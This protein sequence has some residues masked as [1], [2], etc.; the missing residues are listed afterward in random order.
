MLTI[1]FRV[2]TAVGV[3]SLQYREFVAHA[4]TAVVVLLDESMKLNGFS[5]AD[6]P[7]D[8][9]N[10]PAR[11][12][13][14]TI[15]TFISLHPNLDMH[16]PSGHVWNCRLPKPRRKIIRSMRGPAKIKS[17]AASD[18]APSLQQKS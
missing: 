9:C 13:V 8:F 3:S 4:G 6:A 2:K 1:P 17:S 5:I 10:L 11:N 15:L 12:P 18:A 16:E 7:R 14:Q